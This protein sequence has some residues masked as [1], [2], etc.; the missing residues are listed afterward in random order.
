MRLIVVLLM[1][2]VLGVSSAFA[3]PPQ[4]DAYVCLNNLPGQMP[5]VCTTYRAPY[6]AIRMYTPY[7]NPQATAKAR[8][9]WLRTGCPTMMPTL[10]MQITQRYGQLFADPG[11]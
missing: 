4:C 7:Y 9:V 2:V 8:E 11:T 10:V 1:A 5:A 3:S 6:F